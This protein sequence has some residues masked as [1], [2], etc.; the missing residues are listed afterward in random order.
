MIARTNATT[1]TRTRG[2]GARLGDPVLARGDTLPSTESG[3]S[4]RIDRLIGQGGYV[5]VYTARRLG[6][7]RKVPLSLCVKTSRRIDAWIREAY[8][9]QLL[10]GHP[11]AIGTFDAFIVPQ[12]NG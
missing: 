7:S 2:A 5:Q 1:R 3:L 4:Y 8:F 10:D 6:R 12:H 9:G 11:R